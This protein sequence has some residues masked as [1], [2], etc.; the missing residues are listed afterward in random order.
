MT[1][2]NCFCWTRF[3]TEAAQTIEQIFARKEQERLANNGMFFW[4]IGNAIGPSL[5]ALL[6]ET[7]DPEALFS[8]IRS[9]PNS[10][11]VAPPV[12]VAWTAGETL[13]GGVFQLPECSLVTSRY[14]P[15]NP[16]GSHYA[17]V[18][19]SE[20]PISSLALNIKINIS[21]LCNLMTGRPVGASQVTA[22]VQLR[23]TLTSGSAFY[24][25][26][27]RTKLVSPY[28]VRLGNPVPLKQVDGADQWGDVVRSVWERRLGNTVG[29]DDS[30][31]HSQSKLAFEH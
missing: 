25:V 3:G 17:L 5:R 14:N 16:K 15:T 20:H 22:V 23:D 8:P 12:V 6:R 21:N 30:P 28:F 24:P 31:R 13:D 11:D 18:C 9:V 10:V 1:L 27:V 29:K 2:P 26:A 7:S 19:Y 4:G